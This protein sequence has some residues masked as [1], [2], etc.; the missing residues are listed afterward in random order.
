MR[1]IGG[2]LAAEIG[3][4]VGEG[5]IGEVGWIVDSGAAFST[6]KKLFLCFNS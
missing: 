3:E 5:W 4:F 6:I 2:D 1:L